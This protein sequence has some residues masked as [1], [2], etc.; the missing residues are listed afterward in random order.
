MSAKRYRFDAFTLDP[1]D[2]SLSRDGQPVALSARYLDALILLVQEAGRLVSK[3]RFLDEVWR[4]VPVTDEALTQCVK[5]LRQALGDEASRPRFIETAPKHGYRFIAAVE[6]GDGAPV[7]AAAGV[8]TVGW[9]GALGGAAAGLLGGLLYGAVGAAGGMGQLSVLL[10]LVCVT[11]ALAAVGGA[12]VGFGMAAADAA[13]GRPHWRIAGAAVGGLM[14]G[15]VVKL[16]GLDALALLF[17]AA[18]GGITGALD[19]AILGLAAGTGGWLVGR[20]GELGLARTTAAAA[21]LGAAAGAAIVLLGGRLMAGSLALLA[22]TYP[23]SRLRLGG[24][25]GEATFGPASLLAATALEGALF[26]A[27][28]AVAI[29]W[30]GRR[31]AP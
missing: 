22:E 5:A 6:E 20:Y 16:I 28:V 23:A 3:E 27:C 21:A 2:R 14:V 7:T 11:A 8:W 31:P 29:K 17:G 1:A 15:A 18:P 4:G 19:G 9:A 13:A 30:A 26:T 10:V 25:F 12:G 24:L